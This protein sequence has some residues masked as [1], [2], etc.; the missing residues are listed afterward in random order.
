MPPN[1]YTWR[2]IFFWKNPNL[3]LDPD[4]MRLEVVLRSKDM[5]VARDGGHSIS[6]RGEKWANLEVSTTPCS[7]WKS[8]ILQIIIDLPCCV[9]F[10]LLVEVEVSFGERGSRST[11]EIL[12]INLAKIPNTTYFYFLL[13]K[14]SKILYPSITTITIMSLNQ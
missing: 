10:R 12:Q 1:R 4:S 2:A 9:R 5:Q 13:W 14:V 3:N 11:F 6:V 8:E 7:R